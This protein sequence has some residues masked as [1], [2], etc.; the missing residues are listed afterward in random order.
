MLSMARVGRGIHS[1]VDLLFEILLN[2]KMG[3][4][5]FREDF[6]PCACFCASLATPVI[7]V[8]LAAKLTNLRNG[9]GSSGIIATTF[10][11]FYSSMGGSC[12]ATYTFLSP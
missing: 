1:I 4:Q 3:G 2:N 8:S 9:K 7:L 10:K 6:P 11:S 12:T 5:Y